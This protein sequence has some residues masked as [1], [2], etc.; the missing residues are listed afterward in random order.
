MSAQA[1]ERVLIEHIEE[2]SRMAGEDGAKL[3]LRLGA[4]AQVDPLVL[5]A[6]PATSA[7][8]RPTRFLRRPILRQARRP[9]SRPRGASTSRSPARRSSPAA[10]SA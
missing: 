6:A 10:P 9:P 4:R 8:Q 1:Q 5:P 2:L 3:A 7:L